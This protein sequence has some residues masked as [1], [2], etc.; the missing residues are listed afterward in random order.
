MTNN[1]RK[2]VRIFFSSRLERLYHLLCVAYAAGVVCAAASSSA[3][4]SKSPPNFSPDVLTGWVALNYG[5]TFV[6]PLNG[7]GPVV[8]D[9]R[10]PFVS[11]ATS[12]RTGKRSTFHIGIDGKTYIDNFRTPHTEQLHVVERF[13]MVDGGDMLE[14]NIHVEDP[15]AFT[16]PWNAMQRWRRVQQGPMFERV[17]AENPRDLYER[18]TDRVPQTDRP[19]F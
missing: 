1:G 14:A 15:G 13:R 6:P 10:Y 4:E 9:P 8:D 11:N 2:V 5:D 12:A 17:C 19:D 7:P 18:E 16:T 3:Q